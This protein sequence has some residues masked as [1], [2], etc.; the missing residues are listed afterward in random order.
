MSDSTIRVSL[1]ATGLQRLEAVNHDMDFAFIVGDQR[2]D[3]PSF[4][5]EFLSPR[6]AA[7]RSQDITIREF[8]V[9]T[10]DPNHYFGTLLSLGFGHEVCFS[11]SELPFVRSVCGE[12]RN[13]ELFENSLK[14]E[15]GQ[16][17]EDEVEAQIA[18]LIEADDRCDLNIPIV[19]SHF[20]EFSVSDIDQMSLPA[21]RAILSDPTLV[22][23]DED[24]IFELVHRRA[25][26]DFSY[27]EL[28]EFVR[29]EF[30]S[31]ACI[32]AAFDFISE[33]FDSLSFPI[34]SSFRR[35]L[36]LPVNPSH[37]SDRFCLPEIESTIISSVPDFFSV[38]GGKTLRLLY[39]GSRDGFDAAPFHSG[40]DGHPN[41]IS[42]I[43]ST[44][45][46]IFGGY[47]P[48]AWSSEGNYAS[49]MSRESFLFTIE[50]PHN[51][52]AQIFRQKE[53]LRA[54]YH[55]ASYGPTFGCGHD[56]C[57]S[58]RCRDSDDSYSNLGNTYT[59]YTGISGKEV[60]TGDS[61]VGRTISRWR[62]LKFLRSPG[63]ND[64]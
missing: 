14:S 52:P 32:E 12:L 27:F 33:S 11:H 17:V 41:L 7:L 55:R 15:D 42:L 43:L 54:V 8:T 49:D 38:F 5:A 20:Y 30:V 3:C 50:N 58:N 57:V 45:G 28:L 19:A 63:G 1:S 39:R 62:R 34:W 16:I 2:Y 40:C 21:L 51:L 26:S 18:F 47:T 23:L 24:S 29:F 36:T 56:L 22:V 37:E 9:N 59:N 35:R 25:S 4:V 10:E 13:H 44:N 64:S 31:D 53:G 48:V 60:L 61:P 46:S 6:I